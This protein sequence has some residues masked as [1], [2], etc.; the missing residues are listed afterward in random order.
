M[1]VAADIM[2]MGALRVLHASGGRVPEDVAV[3]GFD[4]LLI[5]ATAVPPSQASSSARS[6]GAPTPVSRGR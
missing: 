2:A 4:D 3:V 6:T 1:F 5:A